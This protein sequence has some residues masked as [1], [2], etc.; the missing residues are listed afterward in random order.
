[1]PAR[2]MPLVGGEDGAAVVA[3]DVGDGPVLAGCSS[4]KYDTGR[5]NAAAIFRSVVMVGTMPPRSILWIAAADTSDWAA[6]CW[7]DIPRWIRS[8]RS[9]GPIELT[10]SCSPPRRSSASSPTSSPRWTVSPS[11]QACVTFIGETS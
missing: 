3:A 5:L 9:F 7:S 2:S 11:G 10:I 4:T 6:S 1:M 8:S